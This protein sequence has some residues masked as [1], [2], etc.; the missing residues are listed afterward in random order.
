MNPTASA[1]PTMP[2]I[3]LRGAH[4][5]RADAATERRGAGNMSPE[6]LHVGL[7]RR[8][9]VYSTLLL[10][11]VGIV[12]WRVAFE[13]QA[14]VIEYEALTLAEIVA[15]QAASARS[16]YTQHVVEKLRRD[17]FGAHE[18]YAERPG[19]VALPAQ[20]LKLLGKSATAESAGLYQ[21]RP[22]SKWNLAADQGLRDSF[23]S[24]AW[25]QLIQTC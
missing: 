9:V 11:L 3:R 12:T 24:W 15:R 6:S 25:Q 23:Q 4:D 17:G 16:V 18:D 8:V 7:K 14:R 21:Y 5:D 19:F 2:D 13:S 1:Q 20:F 10:V 22:L